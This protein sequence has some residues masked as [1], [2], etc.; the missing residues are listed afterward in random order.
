MDFPLHI[1]YQKLSFKFACLNNIQSDIIMAAL[2]RHPEL[3]E[4]PIKNK[5]IEI[6]ICYVSDKTGLKWKRYSTK[7]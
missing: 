6:L 3:Q 5:S 7:N 2:I 4:A 1:I